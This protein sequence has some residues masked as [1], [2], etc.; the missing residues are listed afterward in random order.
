[1]RAFSVVIG[2]FITTLSFAQQPRLVVGI[3]VDQMRQEYLWRFGERFEE[4]GFN[5]LMKEGYH[6]KNAHFNY[7]PTYTGPG[8]T[9]VYTGTTPAIHGVIAN[10]WYDHVSKDGV[11]CASDKSVQTVGSSSDKGEMSPKNMLVTSITDELRFSNQ[12]RSKVVG[13]SIKDRGAIFPAGHTGEAYWYDNTTGG[14]ITSTYYHEELPEWVQKFN[15]KKLADRYM[16][17]TWST[18]YDLATYTA[19]GP[20]DAPYEVRSGD[21]DPV[22]PYD[23][24]KLPGDKKYARLPSSPFG[25]DFLTEAAL[26]AVDGEQLGQGDYTD[27]LAISYSSTDYIG[28]Q[29][30]PNSVEVEDTYLRLDKN[31]SALL[32]ALDQKVGEGNYTV[33]LTADHAVVDVPQ[34]LIDNKVQSGYFQID[35]KKLVEAFMDQKY[36]DADWVETISNNQ[37]F[38]NRDQVRSKGLSLSDVQEELVE[39]LISIEGVAECYAASTLRTMDFNTSGVKGMMVRGYNQSRSG[40]VLYALRPGWLAT[41]RKVGTS[42]GSPYSYDTHVPMLWYGAGIKQGSSVKYHPITD[43]V[44]TLSM[45]LEIKLPN[46]VTGQPIHELF[47]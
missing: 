11:Y 25:N 39:F 35:V 29:F 24:S 32:K 41:S 45:M 34:F 10:S 2:L 14:F 3:I 37:L 4:G 9:S 7:V 21:K 27:F 44:P 22:F 1:M 19:S 17:Q 43:I 42:H 40:D 18:L 26:A 47:D 38:L 23:M 13:L 16:K 20:D 28:H 6:F 31:I 12:M 46:G 36:E 33:F 8:H 5:R 30:G 15:K